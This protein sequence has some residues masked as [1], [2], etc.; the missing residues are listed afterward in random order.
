MSHRWEDTW[1]EIREKRIRGEVENTE[2]SRLAELMARQHMP[3]LTW[4]KRNW[5]SLRDKSTRGRD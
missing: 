3:S 2:A 1:K 4:T 5:F